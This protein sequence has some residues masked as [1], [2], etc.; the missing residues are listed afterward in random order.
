MQELTFEFLCKLPACNK[1]KP[2]IILNV[3]TVD[4]LAADIARYEKGINF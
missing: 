1:I 2:H 3:C 4:S